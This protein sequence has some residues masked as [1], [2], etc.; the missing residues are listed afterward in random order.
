MQST[1]FSKTAALMLVMV[2]IFV[3]CLEYYWRSRGFLPTYNDDKVLWANQRKKVYQPLDQATVFIGGSR[4]KYDLDIPT[5]EKVTGE[6][7][8]QL[9]L[10]GTPARLILRDLANDQKFR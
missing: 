3:L 10:V 5:W 8:I 4:I 2:A 6:K 1:Q 7:A 9:A